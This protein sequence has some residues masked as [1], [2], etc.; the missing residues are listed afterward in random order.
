MLK[1]ALGL[2]PLV[3]VRYKNRLVLFIRFEDMIVVLGL[4]SSVPTPLP[5]LMTNLIRETA[6]ESNESNDQTKVI[7]TLPL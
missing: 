2:I 3:T 7:H 4:E 6:N 1:P 5:D